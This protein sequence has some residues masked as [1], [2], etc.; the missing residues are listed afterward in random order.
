M[1][2]GIWLIIFF[3]LFSGVF[4]QTK[5]KQIDQCPVSIQYKSIAC[6][7]SLNCIELGNQG[8]SYPYG[9]IT[10]D[11]GKNWSTT[12]QD[13]IIRD[14]LRK[15]IWWP[16]RV[17]DVAYPDSN[18][19]FVL[20]DFGKYWYSKDKGKSWSKPVDL[21]LNEYMESWV[22]FKNNKLGAFGYGQNFYLTFN[23]PE[24]IT[25]YSFPDSIT[26]AGISDISIID[27]N[28]IIIFA[29]KWGNDRIIKTENGGNT[30]IIGNVPPRPISRIHFFD[31]LNGIG[32]GYYRVDSN[33]DKDVILLTRDGG[34]TWE[35]K[36]DSLIGTKYHGLIQ[37][38]FSDR[39]NGLAMGYYQKLWRTKDGGESWFYD[40]TASSTL[41]SDMQQLTPRKII[42]LQQMGGKTWMLDE[43]SMVSVEEVSPIADE[44]LLYP[45]PISSGNK[46]YLKLNSGIPD[47]YSLS[48]Y[49]ALGQRVGNEYLS[50]MSNSIN[51]EYD[52][53]GLQSGIYFLSIKTRGK[54][55]IKSFIVE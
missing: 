49:N 24:N 43:D 7:D 52:T 8:L 45:N 46:L 21:K 54:S 14:S 35:I 51:L 22:T 53:S 12:F 39:M 19:I 30:W 4:S 34:N 9:R 20:C 18:L 48:L 28:N 29:F 27:S 23:G 31:K 50:Q 15:V 55:I 1:K 37:I 3:S 11:G 41:F 26:P 25:K 32:V 38:S 44:V 42:G 2:Q 6:Y 47:N 13:T 36:V 17:L 33:T 5:W 16:K 10:S 40:T